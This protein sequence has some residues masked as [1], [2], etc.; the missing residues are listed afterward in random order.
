MEQYP[1]AVTELIGI[2]LLC[3]A[4]EKEPAVWAACPKMIFYADVNGC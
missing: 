4:I 1:I 3:S 2:N